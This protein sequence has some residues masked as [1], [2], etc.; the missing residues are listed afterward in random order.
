MNPQQVDFG[1]EIGELL[2]GKTS[3]LGLET[4][5]TIQGVNALW[6]G[7]MPVPMEDDDSMKC[8]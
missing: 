5:G 4:T 8:S 1:E 3:T 6:P 2:D 7:H